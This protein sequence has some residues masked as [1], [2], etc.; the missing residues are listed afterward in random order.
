MKIEVLEKK[1]NKL[2][3]DI[4]ADHTL[5]NILKKELW[6]DKTVTVSGYSKDHIQIGHPRFLI[7][8][9]DPSKS[10]INAAKRLKKQNVDFLNSFKAAK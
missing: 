1:K 7:E 4:E 9:D 5:C 6:N 10:L 2:F 8:G 3:L